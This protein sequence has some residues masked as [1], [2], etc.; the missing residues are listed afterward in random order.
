SEVLLL[1]PVLALEPVEDRELELELHRV[2]AVEAVRALAAFLV[3]AAEAE[4]RQVLRPDGAEGAVRRPVARLPGGELGAGV[5]RGLGGRIRIERQVQ[6]AGPQR[7]GQLELRA[8]RKVERAQQIQPRAIGAVAGDLE[9]GPNGGEA[10]L[11]PRLV[12]RGADAR[13]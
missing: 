5:P 8:G 9:L 11:A 1:D 7:V 4:A 2:A 12:D 6:R 10:D 13:A 3:I